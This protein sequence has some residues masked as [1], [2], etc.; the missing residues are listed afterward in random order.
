MKTRR[1]NAAALRNSTGESYITHWPSPEEPTRYLLR[2]PPVPGPEGKP[3]RK[4]LRYPHTPE[5]LADARQDRDDFLAELDDMEKV[6]AVTGHR[7]YPITVKEA[8]TAFLDDEDTKALASYVDVKKIVGR[9]SEA[10]GQML[11]RS[12]TAQDCTKVLRDQARSGRSESGVKKTR[13]YMSALFGFVRARRQLQ[14]TEWM[15][16]IEMPKPTAY[17][18]EPLPRVILSD[19]QFVQFVTCEAVPL[20]L[21]V[22]AALSR[23]VG[24]A[25]TSDLHAILWSA[26]DLERGTVWLRRPKT[27]KKTGTPTKPHVIPRAALHMLKVWW[28]QQGRPTGDVPVFP[29]PDGK[30]IPARKVSYARPLRRALV[31]AGITD[32]ALLKKS[33]VTKPVDFHS[34]RRSFCTGLEAEDERLAMRLAG[35]KSSKTHAGY[36][37]A[38]GS[39]EVPE[40]ALPRVPMKRLP[41]LGR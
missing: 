14:T 21:R 38:A 27:E 25:R 17:R 4:E 39:M 15:K 36:V 9:I 10:M 7:T 40:R 26:V 19:D 24:G 12:V 37:R 23:L 13:A 29:G 20:L 22:L 31:L 11:C 1:V 33:A 2:L 5:G 3:V 34:F 28:M 32:P 30:C 35:H 16:D 41:K 18:H 6:A 8:C